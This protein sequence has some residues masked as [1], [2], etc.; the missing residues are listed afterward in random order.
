[1]AKKDAEPAKRANQQTIDQWVSR[2]DETIGTQRRNNFEFGDLLLSA[3]SELSK[4]AFK[5]VLKAS[6]LKSDSNAYNYMR[7][8]EKKHLRDPDIIDHLPSTLGVLIDLAGPNWTVGALKTAIKEGVLNPSTERGKLKKWYEKKIDIITG[9]Q[10]LKDL[11]SQIDDGKIIGYII[12]SNKNETTYQDIF[13]SKDLYRLEVSGIEHYVRDG[14]TVFSY[15]LYSNDTFVDLFLCKYP[16]NS[17]NELLFQSLEYRVLSKYGDG[18]EEQYI[19]D[20]MK[21]I[22]GEFNK[23]ERNIAGSLVSYERLE[24][25]LN[26]INKNIQKKI[27]ITPKEISF[28]KAYDELLK[29]RRNLQDE[30]ENKKLE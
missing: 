20:G 15:K 17:Y 19:I 25:L 2:I 4:S 27:S 22:F 1:M 14:K 10:G 26:P 29:A 9:K 12:S 24:K 18:D 7:V 8:A 3:E 13:D 11:Q 21:E 30:I 28:I 16:L 5:K 6:G 23:L